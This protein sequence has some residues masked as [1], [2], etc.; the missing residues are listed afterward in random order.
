MWG[1]YGRVVA[2][3]LSETSDTF[4]TLH[5]SY[6]PF[7]WKGERLAFLVKVNSTDGY[8][9]DHQYWVVVVGGMTKAEAIDAIKDVSLWLR[10][11]RRGAN[12]DGSMEYSGRNWEFDGHLCGWPISRDM[13]EFTGEIRNL[14]L[15]GQEFE[16]EAWDSLWESLSD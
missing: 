10:A 14:P 12:R 13:T 2:S 4:I 3:S 9:A 8:F 1:M 6:V 7:Q 11:W 5:P 15:R 16:I